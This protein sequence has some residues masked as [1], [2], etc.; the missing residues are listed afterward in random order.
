MAIKIENIQYLVKN[1]IPFINKVMPILILFFLFTSITLLK[2]EK[3]IDMYVILYFFGLNY[4]L[5]LYVKSFKYYKV[6]LMSLILFPAIVIQSFAAYTLLYIIYKYSFFYGN[7]LFLL[8]IVYYL[9]L[10]FIDYRIAQKLAISQIPSL[11]S[12]IKRVREIK[13]RVYCLDDSKL[14]FLLEKYNNNEN[15]LSFITIK[16]VMLGAILLVV[17]PI[18]VVFLRMF[19]TLDLPYLDITASFGM[20]IIGS[21]VLPHILSGF[22]AYLQLDLKDI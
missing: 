12:N 10:I 5:M 2:I 11:L 7:I 1:R 22:L 13:E 21:A 17:S 20:F 14:S 16:I 8:F 15:N 6:L 18:I 19:L 4:L 9:L 3:D